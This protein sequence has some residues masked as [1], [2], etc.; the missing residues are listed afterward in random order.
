MKYVTADQPSPQR[1][2]KISGYVITYVI[3]I[4]IYNFNNIKNFYAFNGIVYCTLFTLEMR[5]M[6][7]PDAERN[8]A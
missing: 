1:K 2:K 4:R 3:I 8:Y 5:I 6:S 7:S